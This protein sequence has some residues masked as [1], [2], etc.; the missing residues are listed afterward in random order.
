ML[1][2]ELQKAVLDECNCIKAQFLVLPIEYSLNKLHFCG[3]ANFNG[4]RVK[5]ETTC[6]NSMKWKLIKLFETTIKHTCNMPCNETYY[7]MTVSSSPWPIEPLQLSFYEDFIKNKSY[8]KHFAAYEEI[9][10]EFQNTFDGNKAM[11]DLEKHSLIE[12]NFAKIEIVLPEIN[13]ELYSITYQTTLS[14]LIASVGGS[15][16]LLSGISAI[17]LIE[18]LDLIIKLKQTAVKTKTAVPQ[19]ASPRKREC[20]PR[21][22][23]V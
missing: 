2:M 4:T 14:S 19:A 8:A 12:K 22:L 11:A 3:S 17:I 16:N 15:L 6:V 7:T 13:E 10:T 20:Y 5:N 9:Y 18:V 23:H 1:L 21:Y